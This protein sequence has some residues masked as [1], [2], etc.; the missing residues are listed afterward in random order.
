MLH[1][2]SMSTPSSPSTAALEQQLAAAQQQHLAAVGAQVAATLAKYALLWHPA[3]SPDTRRALASEVFAPE[4]TYCDPTTR[5]LLAAE[6]IAH[7]E[8]QV[9]P[10]LPHVGVARLG[11]PSLHHD[12]VAFSWQYVDSHGQP[13]SFAGSFGTDFVILSADL[14]IRQL[15][16]FF[17]VALAPHRDV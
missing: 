16:G 2:K 15:V 6:L 9:L 10:L 8:T 13:A 4:A 17:G 1:E 5:P 12:Y 14:R 3:T 11:Q 7:I